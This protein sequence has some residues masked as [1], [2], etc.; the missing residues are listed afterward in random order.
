MECIDRFDNEIEIDSLRE[1]AVSYISEMNK[2]QLEKLLKTLNIN[3]SEYQDEYS[4]ES[5]NEN[6]DSSEFSEEE[7]ENEFSQCEEERLFEILENTIIYTAEEEDFPLNDIEPCN[8][9]ENKNLEDEHLDWD[10]V[11]WNYIF[12][13]ELSNDKTHVIIKNS[14]GITIKDFTTAIQIANK[15]EIS[16]KSELTEVEYS[17]NNDTN[18]V[19]VNVKFD[20]N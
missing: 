8:S 4:E 9:C 15:N 3:N 17:F 16:S 14:D 5:E 11:I 12:T 1:T 6:S 20:L 13:L 19:Y 2:E 10:T 7:S 18:T